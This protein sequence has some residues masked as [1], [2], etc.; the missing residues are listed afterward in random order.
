MKMAAEQAR[1]QASEAEQKLAATNE[2]IRREQYKSSQRLQELIDMLNKDALN[3]PK[4]SE[5]KSLEKR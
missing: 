2:A 4:P 1:Q 5:R 3:K